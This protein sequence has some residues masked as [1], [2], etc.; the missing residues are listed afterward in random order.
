MTSQRSQKQLTAQFLVDD[1]YRLL[2]PACEKTKTAQT[3]LE[4]SC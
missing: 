2:K 4:A 1:L 3:P